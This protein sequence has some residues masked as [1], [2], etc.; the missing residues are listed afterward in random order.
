[1]RCLHGKAKS[2]VDSIIKARKE[3]KVTKLNEVW[4]YLASVMNLYSH[5]IVG[6]YADKH[7][8]EGICHKGFTQSL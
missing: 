1:M 3:F 8:E 2:T 6:R 7:N 4:L 5:N